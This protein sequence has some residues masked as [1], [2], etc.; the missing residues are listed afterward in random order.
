MT[1]S[2]S[3]CEKQQDIEA[4][5]RKGAVRPNTSRQYNQFC[6]NSQ[7]YACWWHHPLTFQALLLF[8][9]KK[10]VTFVGKN[11]FHLVVLTSV[12]LACVFPAEVVQA[13]QRTVEAGGG[14]SGW[15]RISAGLSRTNLLDAALAAHTPPPC[16]MCTSPF[17]ICKAILTYECEKCVFYCV[18]FWLM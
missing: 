12:C 6:V 7:E 8:A 1:R 9:P 18:V 14:P 17:C 16:L 5:R 3:R 15:D 2:P 4:E 11:F 10:A 13:T